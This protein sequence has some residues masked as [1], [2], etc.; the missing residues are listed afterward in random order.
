MFYVCP[1]NK[2]MAVDFTKNCRKKFYFFF[3]GIKNK[4]FTYGTAH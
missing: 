3:T 1:A 4:F 2:L